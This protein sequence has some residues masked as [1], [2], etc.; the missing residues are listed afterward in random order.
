MTQARTTGPL[1]ARELQVAGLVA[2]GLR[3]KQVADQLSISVRTVENHLRA[4]YAKAGTRT[5]VEFVNWLAD[6]SATV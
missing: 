1:T 4:A 5:R 6:N 3:S 2:Q